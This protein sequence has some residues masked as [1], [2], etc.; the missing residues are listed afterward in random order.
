MKAY[1]QKKHALLFKL[2]AVASVVVFFGLT[3]GGFFPSRSSPKLS[4]TP[5]SIQ[6]D[7]SAGF[8]KD[9]TAMLRIST[10]QP[11]EAVKA[12]ET[13]AGFPYLLFVPDDLEKAKGQGKTSAEATTTTYPLIVFL[14]GAGESGSPQ[15]PLGI[16]QAGA[17]GC[18]FSIL[19]RIHK[20]IPDSEY[21]DDNNKPMPHTRVKSA[22][23]PPKELLVPQSIYH[24]LRH[25]FVVVAPRTNRGWGGRDVSNF[26]ETFLRERGNELSIDRTRVTL[27]GVSMGGGGV[28]KGSAHSNFSFAALVPVCAA[29][30]VDDA[31]V[32]TTPPVWAFHAANDACVPVQYTDHSIDILKAKSKKEARYTRDEVGPPPLAHPHLDGHGN[33]LTAYRDFPELYKWIL[34][35]RSDT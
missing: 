32:A 6:S 10:D 16:L 34:E 25:D 4:R 20:I 31:T 18:I 27:T 21:F 15:E 5:N 13:K 17:S 26:V 3:S 7:N 35:Q 33:W 29:G 12:S 14:H 11:Y 24:T 28:W 2:I 1:T 22:S 8:Q 23:L 9:I 19:A 30:R